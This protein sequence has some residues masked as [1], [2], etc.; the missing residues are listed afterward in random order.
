MVPESWLHAFDEHMKA[1]FGIDHQD[2]GLSDEEL[3]RYTDLEPKEAALV[4]GEDYDLDRI[5]NKTW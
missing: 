3:L 5:D 4:Y 2:A 1:F